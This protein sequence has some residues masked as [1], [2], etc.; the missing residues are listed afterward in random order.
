ME[1]MVSE[2]LASDAI[3]PLFLVGD[4]LDVLKNIPDN[5]IDC[6]ITSPP[7]WNKRQYANGGIGLEK[8]YQDYISAL[9]DIFMEVHRVCIQ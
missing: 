2:Y 7:Y 3:E 4:A 1:Y 6:C 5:S 9:V 8:D